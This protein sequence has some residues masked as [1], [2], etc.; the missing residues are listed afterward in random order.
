M[1]AKII[2][3]EIPNN[4]R[5]RYVEPEEVFDKID[6]VEFDASQTLGPVGVMMKEHKH[7]VLNWIDY[8]DFM[9]PFSD[10][11]G[12]TKEAFT[13]QKLSFNSKLDKLGECT[14]ILLGGE[15]VV[16]KRGKFVIGD[17]SHDR[18]ELGRI[19]KI[20]TEVL[21][22]EAIVYYPEE[23]KYMQVE[24]YQIRELIFDK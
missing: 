18:Q 17:I 3:F 14:A 13:R 4:V 5:Q 21:F 20:V 24:D 22:F 2:Q 1:S 12:T 15:E 23:L 10:W 6:L 8:N 9:K 7:M 11:K 16:L 19:M